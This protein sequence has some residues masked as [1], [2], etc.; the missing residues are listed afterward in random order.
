MPN[1]TVKTDLAKNA[2]H[3]QE[4]TLA[5]VNNNYQTETITNLLH[6][7]CIIDVIDA[8]THRE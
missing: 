8:S 6:W 3:E 4:L 1:Y 7:Q 5:K 2:K